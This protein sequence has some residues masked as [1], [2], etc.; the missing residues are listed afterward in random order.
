[1][2][3]FD[4]IRPTSLEEAVILLNDIRYINKLI[5]GG[6]DLMVYLHREDPQFNRVIDISLLP[7]LKIIQ[8]LNDQINLGAGVTFSE[9][10]KSKILNLTVPFLVNACQAIGSP[11]I[12]NIGTIGGNIANAAACADTLPVLVCLDAIAHLLSGNEARSIPVTELII[13]PNKTK[14]KSNEI[15]T[16]FT[17]KTPASGTRTKYIK[18]GRRN[19]QAISRL[20][21]AIMG[22]IDSNN[23]IDYIHITPGSATPGTTRFT[24]AE[25]I[26]IGKKPTLELITLASHQVAETMI[27]I[28][29]RRWST[30]YK[31]P[32][33]TAIS[34]RALRYIFEI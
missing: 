17:F 23:I 32:A 11:Q 5:A 6:T 29:G 15:L 21:I 27:S 22:K 4:F 9:A 24:D 2:S 26:L 8:Q 7:E 10:I 25:G 31:E 3:R 28:T 12:R 33:L 20:T 18:L 1:M 19:A 16:H 30:E 34:E 13:G 14:I